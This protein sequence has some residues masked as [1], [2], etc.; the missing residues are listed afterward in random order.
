MNDANRGEN[1]LRLLNGFFLKPLHETVWPLYSKAYDKRMD[2]PQEAITNCENG[3]DILERQSPSTLPDAGELADAKGRCYLLL[4]CIYLNQEAELKKAEENFIHSREIYHTKQAWSHLESLAYLGLAIT[5]RKSGRLTGASHECENADDSRKR[6]KEN[7]EVSSQAIENLRQA[8]AEERTKIQE[9]LEGEEKPPPPGEHP[10]QLGEGEKE[11]I[12]FDIVTG[13]NIIDATKDTTELNC[14]LLKDYQNQP[15]RREILDLNNLPEEA[16]KADYILEVRQVN[17]VSGGL[18]T[19]DLIFIKQLMD[20]NKLKGK[21]VAVLVVSRPNNTCATLKIFFEYDD[22]YFLRGISPRD[23]PIII[24]KYK[25]KLSMNQYY[26]N[27]N[28]IVIKFVYDIAIS[29]IVIG[30]LR[31]DVFIPPENLSENR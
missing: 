7:T 13:K 16:R 12:I 27:Y 29:G 22:H 6:S 23:P 1:I 8:I 2:N 9:L 30:I 24:A 19:N 28:P 20:L 25:T 10:P 21:K 14:L 18:Q 11:F 15:L 26:Q 5:L 31:G 3:L 17:E 4:A